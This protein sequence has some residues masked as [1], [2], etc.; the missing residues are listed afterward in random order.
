MYCLYF[1]NAVL[2][3]FITCIFSM[4]ALHSFYTLEMSNTS[5][6]VLVKPHGY[7]TVKTNLIYLHALLT[8]DLQYN[9]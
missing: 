1:N 4:I 5:V 7:L 8:A 9:K 6:R 3:K 2:T